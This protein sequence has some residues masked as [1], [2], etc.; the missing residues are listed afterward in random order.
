MDDARYVLYDRF[1]GHRKNERSEWVALLYSQYTAELFFPTLAKG[2]L[3]RVP[4]LDL[5]HQLTEVRFDLVQKYRF[6]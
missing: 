3:R 6:C 2:T 1:Q 5:R 4:V